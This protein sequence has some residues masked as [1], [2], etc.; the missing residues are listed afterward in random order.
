MKDPFATLTYTISLRGSY[1]FLKIPSFFLEL[2]IICQN[3]A[4]SRKKNKYF[5][6]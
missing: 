1:I 5:A 3:A 2:P 4:I 6:L